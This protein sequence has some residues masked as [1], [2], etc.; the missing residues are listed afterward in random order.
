VVGRRAFFVNAGVR[1]FTV[2]SNAKVGNLNADL[3][4]GIDST[5]F[6]RNKLP[7]ALTGSVAS[8]G[9]FTATNTGGANGVQGVSNGGGAGGVFG[10]NS[11][12]GYGV[13]GT[14]LQPNGV[15]VSGFGGGYGIVGRSDTPGGVGVF[16]T[17]LGG[18]DAHAVSAVANGTGG[19]AMA[20]N[21]GAGPAL[22]LHSTGAPITVGSSVKVANLNADQLDGIDSTQLVIGDYARGGRLIAIRQTQLVSG[23]LLIIPGLGGLFVDGCDNNSALLRFDALGTGNFDLQYSGLVANAAGEQ[24][25]RVGA[26]ISVLFSFGPWRSGFFTLNIARGT[27]DSTKIATIWVSWYAVGCR[28]QAQALV[29][30]QL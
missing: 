1:P 28:F 16:G 9:V 26:T 13:A 2:N 22:E 17:A 10:E 3:V 5:G 15:G 8:T 12:G 25:G 23:P 7:L 20:R 11:G 24:A 6:L 14:S 19:A 4:D 29:S 30:P 21:Q 18:G 27:F